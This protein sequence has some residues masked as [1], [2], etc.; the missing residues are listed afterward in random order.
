[1]SRL[2]VL[3]ALALCCSLVAAEVLFEEKFDDGEC[4]ATR[5]RDASAFPEQAVGQRLAR[6]APGLQ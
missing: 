5:T 6:A 1:M 4:W 3:G 2:L